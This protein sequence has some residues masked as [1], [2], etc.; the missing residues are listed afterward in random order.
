MYKC[1]HKHM[2][3]ENAHSKELSHR[4][5]VHAPFFDIVVLAGTIQTEILLFVHWKFQECMSFRVFFEY[6]NT[7]YFHYVPYYIPV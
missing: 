2:C 4:F 7:M 6:F 1:I 5:C 3:I